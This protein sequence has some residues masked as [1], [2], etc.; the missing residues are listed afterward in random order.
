M[1]RLLHASHPR[2]A[3]LYLFSEVTIVF[4]RLRRLGADHA[5][6]AGAVLSALYLLFF[7][8]AATWFPFFNPYLL[9]LGLSG[10]QIGLLGS[11]R[12]L[13]VLVSQPLWGM[14][15][16][17][18]GRRKL[19]ILAA[20]CTSLVLPGYYFGR[21]LGFILLWTAIVTTVNNPIGSMLDSVSLDQVERHKRFSYGA[22]RLWGAAGWAIASVV[23]GRLLAGRDPRM[24]FVFAATGFFGMFLLATRIPREP[25]VQRAQGRAWAGVGLVLR[26]RSVVVLLVMITAM[27]IGTSPIFAFY[28]IYLGEL[29]ASQGL[30]GLAFSIQGLSEVP[31][32]LASSA[33]IRRIGVERAIILGMCAYAIRVLLY[34]VIRAPELAAAIEATHG[35]TF[36]LMFVAAVHYVNAHTPAEWRATGQSLLSAAYFGVGAI[37]GSVVGGM[38]FDRVGVRMLYRID[39]LYILAIA[40]VALFVLRPARRSVATTAVPQG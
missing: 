38:L 35:V 2:R 8:S 1:V 13:V 14:A 17:A 22:V 5:L 21:T 9:S 27:Q 4:G 15:A 20:L 40:A 26:Q 39:G 11:V 25:E 6:R 33:I 37:V 7:G 24:M 3:E 34:S 12:P 32:F 29:G 19:L 18:H 23:A 31:V 10:A 16:D 30:I 36:S 28:S